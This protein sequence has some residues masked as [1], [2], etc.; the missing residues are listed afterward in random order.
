MMPDQDVTKKDD[1][2]IAAKLALFTG[3]ASMFD[4]DEFLE[5]NSN[6]KLH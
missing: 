6:L 2:R 1:L 3:L 5:F 4:S